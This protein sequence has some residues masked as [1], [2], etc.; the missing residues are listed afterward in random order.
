MAFKEIDLER[1]KIVKRLG[2]LLP[3]I[4]PR[5]KWADYIPAD[6]ITTGQSLIAIGL[7]NGRVK[8]V[9]TTNKSPFK[10][11]NEVLNAMDDYCLT[12]MFLNDRQMSVIENDIASLAK[13][14][15][16]VAHEAFRV[17]ALH[18]FTK[19][20]CL[21]IITKAQKAEVFPAFFPNTSPVVDKKMIEKFLKGYQATFIDTQI[22]TELIKKQAE[23]YIELE[24]EENE[25]DFE[26]D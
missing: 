15:A 17:L 21:E 4:D 11:V 24:T 2:S 5:V 20:D 23:K 3:Q 6:C 25:E 14:R 22:I 8:Y 18:N 13:D 10:L 26:F 12:T 9:D 1:N 19:E 16:I 7:T